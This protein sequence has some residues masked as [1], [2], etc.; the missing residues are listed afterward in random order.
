MTTK[1]PEY[2]WQVLATD[3]FEFNGDH[4]L[5]VSDYF[6]RFLELVRL[7]TT[8]SS[9]VI[10]AMKIIFSRYGIPEV[11]H[12]DNGPQYAYVAELELS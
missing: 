11:L 4:Y 12:S 10:E 6:S 1:L 8:T 3:L 7:T 2:H 9:S 5:L